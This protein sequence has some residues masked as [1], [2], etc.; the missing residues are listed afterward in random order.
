MSKDDFETSKTLLNPYIEIGKGRESNPNNNAY[1]NVSTFEDCHKHLIMP[2]TD[3]GPTIFGDELKEKIYSVYGV[4]G[5]TVITAGAWAY[6]NIV[7]PP[8]S[9]TLMGFLLEDIIKENLPNVYKALK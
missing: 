1:V 2:F 9:R 5:R 3:I 6:L 7:E 4:V 8:I